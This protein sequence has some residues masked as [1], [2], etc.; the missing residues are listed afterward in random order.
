MKTCKQIL[1]LC[2]GAVI[3]SPCYGS[4]SIERDSWNVPNCASVDEYRS[5]RGAYVEMQ[6]VG[7]S[8]FVPRTTQVRFKKVPDADYVLFIFYYGPKNQPSVLQGWFGPYA[9]NRSVR[10]KSIRKSSI[11]TERWTNFG[12]YKVLDTYGETK[13]GKHWH[14]LDLGSSALYY[15]D[16]SKEGASVFESMLAKMCY[17]PW[18]P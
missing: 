10:E 12:N 17:E 3:F 9:S 8:L 4:Q 15:E 16:A 2:F 13:D 11:F 18:K 14:Y 7:L 1:L 6:H 5:N